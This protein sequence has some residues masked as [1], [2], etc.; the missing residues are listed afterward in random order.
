MSAQKRPDR[1]KRKHNTILIAILVFLIL[2]AI[3]LAVE[4]IHRTD[5]YL[6]ELI[7]FPEDENKSGQ[8]M[9]YDYV[10]GASEEFGVDV[11]IIYAVIYCE[12]R[13]DADATSSAGAMGLMQMMPAT[14]EEMQ[15]YLKETHDTEALFEPE[16]SIRYGTYY[17]SRLYRT[18]EDWE[19]VFAAYNAG[20][21]IV[22]KWLKDERY[23]SDGK[24]IQIPYPETARY[25]EKVKGMVEKYNELYQTEVQNDT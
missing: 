10:S 7:Y 20:P 22:L 25:V 14:F 24:L 16:V 1:K 4:L 23:A 2:T 21:T 11:S 13:F 6:D 15:G 17:L 19:T 18:F 8:L 9:Y 12:S 3:V 5:D